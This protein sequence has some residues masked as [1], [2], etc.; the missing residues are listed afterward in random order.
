M[1]NISVIKLITNNIY[2]YNAVIV[3]WDRLLLNDTS[4]NT[5]NLKLKS[6][7]RLGG[8]PNLAPGIHV[9]IICIG[10]KIKKLDEINLLQPN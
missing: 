3:A 5:N 10:I 7:N 9:L 8:N 1:R 6:F 2:I 4:N